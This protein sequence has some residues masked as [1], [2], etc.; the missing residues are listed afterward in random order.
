MFAVQHVDDILDQAR[1]EVQRVKRSARLLDVTPEQY[2]A[3]PCA[4]GPSLSHSV[5]TTLLNRSPKHAWLE[6]P[7]LGGTRRP[8]TSAMDEGALLHRLLLGKGADF[9]LLNAPDY[10]TKWARELRDEVRAEGKI[11]I[12]THDYHD[13][14]EVTRRVSARCAELGFA[15][16]GRSEVAIEFTEESKHGLVTCRCM[17]DH[18][19]D[20]Q[21]Q[22][23]DLKRV[24][25]VNPRDLPRAIAEYGYDIQRAA[26]LRA[27][28]L[29][30]GQTG[31]AE[32][33][34]LFFEPEPP[35]EV[36][37]AFLGGPSRHYGDSRWQR[38][39][40]LWGK[41]LAEGTYPWPGYS[42][43]AIVIDVPPYALTLELGSDYT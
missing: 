15:L 7:R 14:M 8:P 37:P 27:Y 17:I 19:R 28:E 30:T 2:H 31:R 22:L 35:Y 42:E 38:A 24:A 18:V 10:K 5:A 23:I 26:Y 6:H 36:V 21:L 1:Q 12:L 3:D 11:P 29:L 4:G 25:N 20:E 33:V 40:D 43:G 34:F 16:D 32:F 39:V 41:L 9:Q 13:L